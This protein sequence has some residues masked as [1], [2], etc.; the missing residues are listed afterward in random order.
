MELKCYQQVRNR[1]NTNCVYD[2][3]HVTIKLLI[4][5]SLFSRWYVERG[6]DI[7]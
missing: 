3:F 1:D 6:N 2:L 7:Y 4:E 5:A